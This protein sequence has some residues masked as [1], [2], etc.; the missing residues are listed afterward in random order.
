MKGTA[1]LDTARR[2]GL[3]WKGK[4]AE[5][6]DEMKD[7]EECRTYS[8]RSVVEKTREIAAFRKKCDDLTIKLQELW[9]QVRLLS[10]YL[11]FLS[12]H[13]LLALLFAYDIIKRRAKQ[14]ERNSK[15]K[16]EMLTFVYLFVIVSVFVYLF[17][18]VVVVVYL[19]TTTC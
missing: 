10:F 13:L 17:V 3:V 11:L 1:I 15:S 8:Q 4:Y 12:S 6:Q 18:I 16:K 9:R 7:R 14:E 2:D 5:Q 19:E